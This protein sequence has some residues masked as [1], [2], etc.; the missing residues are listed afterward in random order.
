MLSL[1]IEADMSANAVSTLIGVIRNLFTGIP[2]SY[3]V[4][5]YFT[6]A[7]I[8]CL[9]FKFLIDFLKIIFSLIFNRGGF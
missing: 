8:A 7:F 1:A 5:V 9:T 4:F 2:E 6:M 3:L